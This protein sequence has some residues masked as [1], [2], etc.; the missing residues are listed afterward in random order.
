M[1]KDKG[2]LI[3]TGSEILEERI[4]S[5]IKNHKG[6]LYYDLVISN[7]EDN[8]GD[9]IDAFL[10][11]YNYHDFKDFLKK[12]INIK[13][14][15]D[16]DSINNFKELKTF[17][18]NPKN[19]NNYYPNDCYDMFKEAVENDIYFQ[20]L[21]EYNNIFN[22]IYNLIND[23]VIDFN[24]KNE[25]KVRLDYQ[26]THSW[27]AGMFPSQYLIF[28]NDN[29]DEYSIRFC[30]GHDNGSDFYNDFEINAFDFGEEEEKELRGA[31][32]DF[33]EN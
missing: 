14:N 19:K 26:S 13:S 25:N 18:F 28:K 23:F 30:D 29:G 1:L 27:N 3:M 16:L 22:Q 15:F 7:Y 11:E 31:I 10:E 4:D 20:T 33:F 6:E 8:Y 9:N 21:E 24:E 12:N 17:L 32:K 2:G 5:Y